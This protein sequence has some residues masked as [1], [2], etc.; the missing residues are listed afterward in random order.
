MAWQTTIPFIIRGII[1]D[2]DTPYTYSDSRLQQII[3]VSAQ[4]LNTTIDFQNDYT[5]DIANTGISP[6]PVT[7]LDNTFINLV[8]L[9]SAC[10]IINGEYRTAGG[11]AINIKSGPDS[12]STV[13]RAN[14]KLQELKLGACKAL[15]DAIWNYQLG[16]AVVGE[17]ILSPYR[18]LVSF[19]SDNRYQ[20]P[21]I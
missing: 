20:E 7:V 10:L 9:K 13:D 4:L 19:P 6:D 21:L 17:T 1:N 18:T 14:N 11:N 2:F 16:N 3:V 15:E 5:I 12:L 8:S